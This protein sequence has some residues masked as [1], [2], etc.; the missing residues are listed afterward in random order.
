MMNRPNAC[1]MDA[2]DPTVSAA[3][4]TK[5]NCRNARLHRLTATDNRP[6][7]FDVGVDLDMPVLGALIVFWLALT[8][9]PSSTLDSNS[10]FI[11]AVFAL[12]VMIA[13]AIGA[14]ARTIEAIHH[15]MITTPDKLKKLSIGEP[16]VEVCVLGDSQSKAGGAS[17]KTSGEAA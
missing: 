12:S 11:L 5:E 7:R 16:P 3:E 10:I 1:A 13:V 14:L 4:L 9:P 8:V 6:S 17:R 15:R 2:A